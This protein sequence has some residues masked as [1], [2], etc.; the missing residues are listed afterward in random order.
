MWPSSPPYGRAG[1]RRRPIQTSRSGGS[2]RLRFTL[3]ACTLCA[4]ACTATPSIAGAAPVHNRG[5]TIHA[6]PTHIIAGEAVFIIGQLKGPDHGNQM[7]R[8][9]HR[10]NPRPG[11]SLIGI[12]RTNSLGQYE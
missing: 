5:L 8:L 4:F 2:M 9:Y 3:L 11:F 7:I 10:I 12:A 6:V 1:N